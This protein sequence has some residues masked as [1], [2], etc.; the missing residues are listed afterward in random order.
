MD[1]QNIG[2]PASSF[3]DEDTMIRRYS[4]VAAEEERL[5]QA[6]LA[7]AA[8][9]SQN[10]GTRRL[11]DEL[12]VLMP[13]VPPGFL[14]IRRSGPT[15][16]LP[17]PRNPASRNAEGI[18]WRIALYGEEMSMRPLGLEICGDAILGRGGD[19][20]TDP[21]VDLTPY[22]AATSGVSRAHALLRPTRNKLY[23]ID[24]QSTN[25]TRCNGVLLGRGTVHALSHNDTIG[26]GS[27]T[28]QVK[29]IEWP[30]MP[31]KDSRFDQTSAH[32]FA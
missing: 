24:L 25:G 31:R 10:G 32:P 21:D 14:A 23:L 22:G 29:L 12:A 7:F 27:L 17:V 3:Q 19:P 16:Y 5:R 28:F 13:D 20:N 26:L 30:N 11:E 8:R 4:E 9:R 6:A 18:Q 2:E 1:Q 15:R